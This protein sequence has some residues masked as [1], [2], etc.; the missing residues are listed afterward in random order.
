MRHLTDAQRVLK[1][2]G[3]DTTISITS[4]TEAKKPEPKQIKTPTTITPVPK[5]EQ[6]GA[7]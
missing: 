1:V 3:I 5:A 4:M 7:N 2:L 6:K